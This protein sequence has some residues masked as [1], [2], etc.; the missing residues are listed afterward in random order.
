MSILVCTEH[1]HRRQGGARGI[2]PNFCIFIGGVGLFGPVL[3]VRVPQNACVPYFLTVPYIPDTDC[4]SVR[5]YVALG[6][7]IYLP[8]VSPQPPVLQNVFYL[9]IESGSI[10]IYWGL[11]PQAPKLPLHLLAFLFCNILL[12]YRLSQGRN[13]RNPMLPMCQQ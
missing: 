4:E 11:P 9:S 3:L 1:G 7:S 12:Q 2:C 6:F 10:I 8:I 5:Q 13:A